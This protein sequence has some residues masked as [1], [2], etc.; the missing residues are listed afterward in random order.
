MSHDC[1]NSNE[2]TLKDMVKSITI[3]QQKANLL[4]VK[5]IM[6]LDT[7][8]F[9]ITGFQNMHTPDPTNRVCAKMNHNCT[10][11]FKEIMRLPFSFI[12]SYP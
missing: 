2:T 11:G 4:H 9:Q 6:Q 5:Y 7:D 3:K 12:Q 8:R 1:S 10:V